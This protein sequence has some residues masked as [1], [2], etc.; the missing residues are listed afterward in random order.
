VSNRLPRALFVCVQNAGRSQMAQALY[1]MRGGEA[2]S[3]GSNPA[4]H[5]HPEVVTVM[6]ELG[7]D[8]A[9]RTPRALTRDDAEWAEV[10]VTMGCG[11]ACPYIPG[12]RYVDWDL[13][14]PA[15]RSVEEVRAVRD[16]INSRIADLSADT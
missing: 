3:A 4:Q 6:R 1:E 14:D 9:S 7:V 13:T 12:R 5:V 10:V 15:G 16:E 2:R 11:D 8:L